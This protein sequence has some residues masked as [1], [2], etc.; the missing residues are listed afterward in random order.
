M[1]NKIRHYEHESISDINGILLVDKPDGMTSHDVV[2]FIKKTFKFKKVGHGGTL[3]PFATGLLVVMLNK[4]TKISQDISGADK[5]Y[6]ADVVFGIKTDTQDPTGR[7]IQERKCSLDK[8]HLT[9]VLNKFTG[10]IE[11]LPPMYSAVK[12]KGKKL[13]QYARKGIDI[14]RTPRQIEIK[15]LTLKT[16]NKNQAGF[17]IKCS[18]GTYIRQLFSDI[19]DEMGCG[20]HVHALRRICSGAYD[21]DKAISFDRLNSLTNKDIYESI[22]RI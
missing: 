4:A 14:K 18:K 7:I 11:Q 17:F 13:Y 22:Q 19:G 10:I 5:V 8:E 9:K 1:E 2:S 6:T 3:D 15:E 20:A 21:I 12:H 16:L